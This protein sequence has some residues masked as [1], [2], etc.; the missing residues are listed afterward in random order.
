MA[1]IFSRIIGGEIPSR[2]VWEDE[3]CVAFLDVRPLAPGHALVVPRVEVDQWTDLD[4]DLVSHLTMV[5]H[6]IGQAQKTVFTP[7]RVGLMIAGFE[8]PHVHIH[9]VPM[10]TMAHLDFSNANTDPDQ[11]ALD[12]HQAD[13]RAALAAEGHSEVS[14]R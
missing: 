4:G 13:L 5:A 12:Q 7:A 11:A 9:V 2:M 14:N 10:N 6:A 3:L 8:V 1:T